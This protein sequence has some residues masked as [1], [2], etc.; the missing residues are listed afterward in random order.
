VRGDTDTTAAIVGA[1]VGAG[2]GPDGIPRE[3][4][5]R[6]WDWPRSVAW[7]Q[8]LARAAAGA[9]AAGK[10]HP[11]PRSLPLLGLVRNGLFLAAVLAHAARRMLPPY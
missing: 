5:R 8:D 4:V 3:W 10:P 6:L 9:V 1:I 2:V 7:M 11:A